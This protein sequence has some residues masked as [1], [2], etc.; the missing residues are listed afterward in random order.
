MVK[1]IEG[2]V[3]IEKITKEEADLFE[4][5]KSKMNRKDNLREEDYVA[6][7]ILVSNPEVFHIGKWTF[8]EK[9]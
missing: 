5:V 8:E 3:V 6:L 1:N 9:R 4:T 2:M 7:S